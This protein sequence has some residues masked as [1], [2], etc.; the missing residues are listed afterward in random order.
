M[1]ACVTQLRDRVQRIGDVDVQLEPCERS[2]LQIA[3]KTFSRS[4]NW[5]ARPR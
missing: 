2:T 5:G 3:V 4:V 1:S